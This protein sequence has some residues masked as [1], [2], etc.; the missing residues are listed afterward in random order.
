MIFDCNNVFDFQVGTHG[1]SANRIKEGEGF[2]SEIKKRVFSK[3]NEDYYPLKLPFEIEK[4]TDRV[5]EI[6]AA[7]Q[8]DFENFVV[9]GMGGSSLGNQMLHFAIN[10]PYYNENLNRTTPRM[11][12][13]DNVDPE[14]TSSLLNNINIKK[15]IFN[16]ITKSGTTGET[17]LNLLI[18]SDI[19]KDKGL[20]YTKH[21]V[22][23]TDPE[24][25]FLR[26]LSKTLSVKTLSI[27]PAVGGRYS[28]LSTVGLLS[29]AVEGIN[30]KDLIK[31]AIDE[32]K[33][34]EEEAVTRV[35]ALLFP[36]IQ[37]LLYTE[38][39]ININTLFAY[40]D[41]LS[42]VGNWYNQL[43]AES[44]GKRFTQD[45]K[46]VFRGI[47]P[48]AL[49]GTTDQHSVLQLL[50]EGPFD[51]LVIFIAPEQYRSDFYIEGN[52]ADDERV[53]YL[54][55]KKYSR[56]IKSEYLATKASLKQN[57]R[58]NI[59]IELPIINEY[60]LGKLI[61]MFEFSVI[62]LGE[63]LEVNPINQPSVE[64][65]KRYTYAMMGR[66]GYE[67]EKGSFR[68]LLIGKKDFIISDERKE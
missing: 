16:I 22:F 2:L 15:T 47:T 7:I 42:Y 10:G 62:A 8:K 18:I 57:G 38:K 58:P 66:K 54:K 30:I 36:F 3:I 6:S 50:L 53:N 19:L 51:K 34:I 52:I 63:M 59:G 35:P 44:I 43:L 46:E 33:F 49:R 17:I 40:S 1:I 55:K 12:F 9:V 39:G 5:I 24:K 31:G 20:G 60:E 41:Y 67:K 25:G 48:L 4:E 56:L 28:A 14:S 21:L 13:L 32:A 27:S 61:Y 23:T 68:S 37:Y 29:A 26:E 64:I 45:G 11:Y 65:G